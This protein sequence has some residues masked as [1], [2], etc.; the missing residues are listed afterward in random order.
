MKSYI[1]ILFL[2]INFHATFSQKI[3]REIKHLYKNGKTMNIY[4]SRVEILQNDIYIENKKILETKINPDT[5]KFII[6]DTDNPIADDEIEKLFLDDILRF[7]NSKIKLD[8]NKIKENYDSKNIE[9]QRILRLFDK[10]AILPFNNDFL[11]S[12]IFFVG[13]LDKQIWSDSIY[14]YL[15]KGV[16]INSYK[17]KSNLGRTFEVSFDSNFYL[18]PDSN[19]EQKPVQLA[20]GDFQLFDFLKNCSSKGTLTID[21]DTKLIL[22]SNY[23]VNMTMAYFAED[24]PGNF[25]LHE[26]KSRSIVSLSNKFL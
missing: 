6:I 13:N 22:N 17:V 20:N 21:K 1:S 4:K 8:K 12:N 25:K 11:I 15:F 10:K 23:D 24:Y 7:L 18:D 2:V 19:Q 16:F 9:N 5:G 26:N 14:S 3:E